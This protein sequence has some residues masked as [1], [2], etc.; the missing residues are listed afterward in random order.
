VSARGR[1]VSGTTVLALFHMVLIFTLR[2]P[3]K[4]APVDPF[5][6]QAVR[7]MCSHEGV[8]PAEQNFFR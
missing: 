4:N 7:E 3:V 2:L 6:A 8:M 1:A 5:G